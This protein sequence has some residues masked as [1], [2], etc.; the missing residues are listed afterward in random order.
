M[1][2]ENYEKSLQQSMFRGK[3]EKTFIDKILSNKQSEEL[4][5]LMEKEDLTRSELLKLLY[6]LTETEIKLLNFNEYDRYLLGKYLVWIREVV[7]IA[8]FFHEF[9]VNFEEMVKAGKYKT[10]GENI[11]DML[12]S[13]NSMILHGVKFQ[14]N[15]YLYLMRST[16]SIGAK[17]FSDIGTNKYEYEYNQKGGEQLNIAQVNKK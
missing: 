13:I 8:E 11:K 6:M 5:T 17:A 4:K 7:H 1:T 12:D 15:I 3:N 9:K 2:T 10:H 16:L 14:A